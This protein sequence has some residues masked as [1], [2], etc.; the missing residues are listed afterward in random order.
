L[1]YTSLAYFINLKNFELVVAFR[2]CPPW[3]RSLLQPYSACG[4]QISTGI[5]DWAKL[6][7]TS[8]RQFK[9]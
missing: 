2:R 1:A 7:C 3:L 4:L 9:L 5:R 6:I 8:I